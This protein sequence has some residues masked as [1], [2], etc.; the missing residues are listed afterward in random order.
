MTAQADPAEL[1]RLRMAVSLQGPRMWSI[2]ACIVATL[3]LLVALA[4]IGLVL[5]R[6]AAPSGAAGPVSSTP[7]AALAP[8]AS[9][10]VVQ[11]PGQGFP[12]PTSAV[13]VAA[14]EDGTVYSFDPALGVYFAMGPDGT[15]GQVEREGI[16]EDV[17]VRLD[18]PTSAQSATG[19]GASAARAASQAQDAIAAEGQAEEPLALNQLL[20]Q[21]EVAGEFLAV[22]DQ[23]TGV[24]V[25]GRRGGE[26]PVYAFMDPRCPFCHAA[27]EDLEGEVDVRWIPT[28]AL[29]AG[30]DG[31]AATLLGPMSAE[32]GE[33][34]AIARVALEPDEGRI[35]RFSRQLRA[36]G[37]GLAITRQTLTPEQDFALQENLT[38]LRQLY[39]RQSA[40][41]GVPTFVVPAEDGTALMLRGYDEQN[42]ARILRATPAKEG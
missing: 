24:T 14:S 35:D 20:A 22:L 15:V 41:M 29:G 4:A 25:E 12:G 36:E 1:Q 28:L 21:P 17:V 23:L 16:P 18:E 8:P 10:P 19:L 7:T 2:V 30:G 26:H 37:E 6:P 11:G 34:G 39:G 38:V 27:F 42:I 3:A 31:V 13:R 33:D 32:H 40:L 9:P 5:L